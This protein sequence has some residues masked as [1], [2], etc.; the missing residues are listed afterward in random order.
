MTATLLACTVFPG[1]GI[2]SG[3]AIPFDTLS[4][5]LEASPLAFVALAYPYTV[6]LLV[7]SNSPVYAFS[8][9]YFPIL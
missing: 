7:T 8:S 9:P 2:I 6:Q 4:I 1:L 3:S 5:F